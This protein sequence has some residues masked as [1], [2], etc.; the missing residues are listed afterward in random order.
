MRPRTLAVEPLHGW[1]PQRRQSRAAFEWLFH[2]E[3]ILPKPTD[4]EPRLRH[5]RNGWKVVFMVGEHR[6]HA[7]G[8][9][10]RTGFVYEFYGC[11]YHGC[12]ECFPRRH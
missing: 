10:P 5:G 9:D 8:Y 6:Y 2:L 1:N 12:P 4:G 11:F 7:D 3:R